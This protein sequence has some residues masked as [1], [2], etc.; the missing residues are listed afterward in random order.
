MTLAA[1]RGHRVVV[2]FAT[3]GEHG[4]VPDDLAPGET[5][6]QR[7]LSEAQAS[8]RVLGTARVAWLG[9][10]DSGMTGWSQNNDPLSFLQAD[11]ASAG[12]RLADILDE[13]DA[14]VL[15]SYDWHGDY[16][17]PDHI[18]AHQVAY[19]AADLARRRPRMLEQTINRD[20]MA[21]MAARAAVLGVESTGEM[22]GDDGRPL[23]M[24][25]SEIGWRVDVRSV[26]DRKRAA[27]AAHGSQ[28]DTQWMLSV[29]QEAFE[30]W[31]GS[32][33][34]RGEGQP[35][36]MVDGWPFAAEDAQLSPS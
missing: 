19:R 33:Y 27:L 2:V 6:A 13:E 4:S 23:G 31:M 21:R 10:R 5:V 30:A 34:Y 1:E 26:L 7:R 22:L 24:P 18:R 15:V 25:E 3:G 36:P 20:D 11:L 32:E 29:P 9:Y 35:S 28:S 17:H 12:R 16:G 8:A 14:D